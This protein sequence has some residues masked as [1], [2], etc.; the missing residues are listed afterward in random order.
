MIS[1]SKKELANVAPI[2]KIIN[3]HILFMFIN[4]NNNERT[5]KE[6]ERIFLKINSYHYPKIHL[7]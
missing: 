1:K 3:V 7:T 6:F 2:D 5:F 4:Y